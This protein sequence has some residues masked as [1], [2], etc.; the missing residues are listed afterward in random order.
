MD[1]SDDAATIAGH[2]SSDDLIQARDDEEVP[3][4]DF[5]ISEDVEANFEDFEWAP[6]ETDSSQDSSQEMILLGDD[7]RQ[8]LAYLP[9]PEP[10]D[11]HEHEE[12]PWSAELEDPLDFFDLPIGLFSQPVGTYSESSQIPIL[13]PFYVEEAALEDEQDWP[14][15]VPDL[16]FDSPPGS[17]NH[18]DDHMLSSPLSLS[19]PDPLSSPREMH[20]DDDED[21]FPPF[22]EEDLL[23]LSP[24]SSAGR[25]MAF[26]DIE[27][28]FLKTPEDTLSYASQLTM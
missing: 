4:D 25:S 27:E 22:H 18:E 5:N 10:E 21:D 2:S 19:A 17:P 13:V 6:E 7:D 9:D 12:Q 3:S 11:F 28:D 23:I 1:A 16:D 24:V 15:D 26:D 14:Q 8:M 20:L